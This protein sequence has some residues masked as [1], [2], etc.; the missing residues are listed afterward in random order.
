MLVLPFILQRLQDRE[1]DRAIRLGW[2]TAGSWLVV[3]VPF[4]IASPSAWLIFLRFNTSRCAEF[5]SL[6]SIGW[7]Y[8][9]HDVGA[10]CSRTGLINLGSSVTFVLI[11]GIV[12]AAKVRRWPDFPRWSLMFPLVVA[13]LLTSKVYSPQYGLWL[14]PLFALALPSL[15]AFV[16]FSLADLAVFVTR[17]W[18]F[19]HLEGLTGVEQWMFELAVLIRAAV[20]V[21]CL[22]LWV[23]REPE[24][25]PTGVR[26]PELEAAPP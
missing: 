3:N 9:D 25:L 7:R 2:A 24:V 1:P 6:W 20:L 19:G 21:S 15:R 26:A 23:L 16:A 14:L 11:F 8:L 17:F 10:S 13:F 22:V 4:L 12:W 5:D 18:W